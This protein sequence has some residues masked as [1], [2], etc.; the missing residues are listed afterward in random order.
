MNLPTNLR[1]TSS[2]NAAER[3][4]TKFIA[5]NDNTPPKGRAPVYRGGRPAFNWAMKHDKYGAACLWLIARQRLLASVV[6]TITSRRRED[7]TRAGTERHAESRRRS[8]ISES[9]WTCQQL[10]LGLLTLNHN[11]PE[12][13]TDTSVTSSGRGTTLTSYQTISC[14]MDLVQ[15]RLRPLAS[16]S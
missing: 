1:T 16:I 7:S 3:L 14:R 15:M 10:C 13:A 8:Q 4:A 2:R 11:R 12:L 6:A 9:I 5:A